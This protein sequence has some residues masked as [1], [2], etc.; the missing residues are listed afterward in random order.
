MPAAIETAIRKPSTLRSGATSSVAGAPATRVSTGSSQSVIISPAAPPSSPSDRLSVSSCRTTRAR[1]APS[2]IRT[3]SSPRRATPCASSRL[4]TLT[5]ASVSS[6]PIAII[7]I[8]RTVMMEV[9]FEPGIDDSADSSST[10]VAGPDS[11]PADG[12]GG[13]EA[14]VAVSRASVWLAATP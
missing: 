2:A 4:A 3:P 5:H 9:R 13:S 10:P 14:T 1:D 7:T 8:T 11:W 12:G 6:S